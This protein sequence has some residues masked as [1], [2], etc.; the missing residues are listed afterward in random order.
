MSI[1]LFANNASSTLAGTLSSGATSMTVAS[2]T[3]ALFPH[4]SA[5]QLFVLTLTDAAT[6]LLNEIVHVTSVSGDTFTIVRAQEGTTAVAWNIGDGAA[7]LWTAG[8]AAALV[9]LQELQ[10][11][12]TNYAVDSGSANAGVV[13]LAPV[14]PSLAFLTGVPIRVKKVASNN[15]G[16]YTLN[17]NGLGATTVE[18]PPGVALGSGS[19]VASEVFEV[20]YNGTVFQLTSIP[21]GIRPTGAAGGDLTGSYPNPTVALNAVTNAKLA[22]MAA[23]TIKSNL[24]GSTADPLDNTL[25]DLLSQLGFT[26]S[27]TAPGYLEIPLQGGEVFIAQW[28]T[29]ASKSQNDGPFSTSFPFTFPNACLIVVSTLINSG[30]SGGNAFDNISQVVSYVAASVTLLTQATDASGAGQAMPHTYIA[31]GF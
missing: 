5:G 12:A 11:Q 26:G 6:G 10:Q 4:P 30:G 8:Q 18:Y 7:N 20:I 23:H 25:D 3:G 9:Q 16:A 31:F 19:L 21:S 28:G 15:T 1:F 17:V 29:T 24:S 14:P 13:T 22:Q 2:G 27:M